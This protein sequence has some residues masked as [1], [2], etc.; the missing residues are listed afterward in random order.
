[1][2]SNSVL[3]ASGLRSASRGLSG[4]GKS[5]FGRFEDGKSPL[6]MRMFLRQKQVMPSRLRLT[7]CT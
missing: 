7:Q 1:M 3:I 2:I 5:F 6:T 4:Q